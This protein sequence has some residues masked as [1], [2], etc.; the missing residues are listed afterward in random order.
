VLFSGSLFVLSVAGV[1]GFALV[2]PVGGTLLLTGWLA[3]FLS[4]FRMP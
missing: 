1:S 2:T 3:V 4:A